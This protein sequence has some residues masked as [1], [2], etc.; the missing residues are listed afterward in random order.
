MEDAQSVLIYTNRL[1]PYSET[2][3]RDHGR[4]LRR[5]QPHFVGCR[6]TEGITLT[7]QETVVVNQGTL[8]GSLRELRFKLNGTAPVFLDKLRAL[9]PSLMHAHFGGCAAIALPI[10]EALDLPLIVTYHGLDATRTVK[11]RLKQTA[12]TPQLYLHRLNRLKQRAD[13]FLTVT[14]HM[15]EVL[16]EHGFPADKI[17]VHNLGIDTTFF[18]PDP[19]MKREPI[20]LF[21]GRL[22][23]KKG[24]EYLIEAMVEVQRQVPEARL[25]VIGD[26]PLRTSL[27]QM[28]ARQLKGYQFLGRRSPAEVKMWMNRARVFSV[29]SIVAASGDREGFG[30]VFLEA[31]ALG[32][33]AVSFAS[34]GIVESVAHGETG[35]LVAEKDIAALAAHIVQ[36]LRDKS[37]WEAFS[38]RGLARVRTQ[39]DMHIQSS[40][41][42][43]IY[44]AVIEDYA[45]TFAQP[46]L[47]A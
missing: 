10:A 42:E 18:S 31:Q 5:Y 16:I 19:S 41:L 6:R 1:L 12:L 43:D 37:T 7:E 46:S 14:E 9:E 34:G 27:E 2:F 38:R 29:P 15:R 33:P 36:L 13:L 32:T 8:L 11:D 22:V 35:F 28:A 40:K 24:C 30:I 17:R 47:T 26:G 20:V 23:E 21:V 25:V 3:I 45:V 44:D 39:F 4:S